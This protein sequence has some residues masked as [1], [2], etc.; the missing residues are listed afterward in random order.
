MKSWYMNI[1]ANFQ[2]SKTIPHSNRSYVRNACSSKAKQA[3]GIVALHNPNPGSGAWHGQSS[4]TVNGHQLQVK[5]LFS[6]FFSVITS[7]HNKWFELLSLPVFQISSHITEI[8]LCRLAIELAD[9]W[10]VETH[11]VQTHI[12]Q[13]TCEELATFRVRAD[14]YRS[15]IWSEPKKDTYVVLLFATSLVNSIKCNQRHASQVQ[16]YCW[17]L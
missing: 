2:K 4:S 7:F 9:F 3:V 5:H 8:S 15:Y 13:Q 10:L 6:L 16:I 12:L 11:G 1:K 14:V 17:I